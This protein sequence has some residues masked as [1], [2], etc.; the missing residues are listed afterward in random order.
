MRTFSKLLIFG[1]LLAGAQ[2]AGAQTWDKNL[3][4]NGDAESGAGVTSRTAPVVKNIPGW[5][6]TGNFTLCQ[7][8]NGM[9][10]DSRNMASE[11]KQYF[12]GGPNGG[13]ATAKQT[14]DLAAGAAEI[15]AGRVRF[16]LSAWL[17]NG[18]SAVAASPKITATFVDA[19]GKTLLEHTV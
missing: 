7:F 2:P 13:P 10:T 8:V 9:V 5:T 12:A 3:V 1:A 17:S 15:D 4:V 11:G 6:T 19:A 16:S 14:I 18:G